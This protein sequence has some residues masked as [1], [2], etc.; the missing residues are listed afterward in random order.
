MAVVLVVESPSPLRELL[1]KT[2]QRAGHRTLVAASADEALTLF[3]THRPDA[4]VLDEQAN[5]TVAPLK[6]ESTPN[7]LPVIVVTDRADPE[8]R[9]A[10]LQSADDV[11]ARPYHPGE[12]AARIEGLLKTRRLA[13]ELSVVRAESGLTDPATGLRN[14]LFLNERVVEEWKRAVRYSE[15]LSLLSLSLEDQAGAL[16]SRGMAFRDRVLGSLGAA[17]R[18]CLRQIDVVA[19]YGPTELGALL[20]NTHL[21]GSLGSADRLRSEVASMR[22]DDYSPQVVMGISFYPGKDVNEPADLMRLCVH[23]LDRARQ[24]GP[25][26]ICLIQHQGYLFGRR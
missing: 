25:G 6:S 12:V 10:L 13:D 20:V 21:A 1:E 5:A 19:R 3:R 16:Q 2:L 18:R 7:L 9:I 24:E 23:A 15:P 14:R 11:V 26:S 22:V 17:L 8:A 4:V